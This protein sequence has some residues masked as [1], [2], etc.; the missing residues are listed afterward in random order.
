MG[1]I[2]VLKASTYERSVILLRNCIAGRMHINSC[3][4]GSLKSLVQACF[5]ML[6]LSNIM[7]L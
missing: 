4:M 5:Q 2:F 7:A 3:G 6:E 1:H